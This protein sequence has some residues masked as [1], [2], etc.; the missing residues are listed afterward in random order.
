MKNASNHHHSIFNHIYDNL[1][2]F[3]HFVKHPVRVAAPLPSTRGATDLVRKELVSAG[4]RR[5]VELGP[6][7]GSLTAGILEALGP[8]EKPLCIEMDSLFCRRLRRRF[9]DRIEIVQGDALEA[10]QIVK[11]TLWEKPDAI[12]SSVPLINRSAHP[13]CET[14]ADMLSPHGLYLQVANFYGAVENYFDIKKTY[15]IMANF[16][17]EH[18]HIAFPKNGNHSAPGGLSDMG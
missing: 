4:V 17:P 7:L 3:I 1:L 14:I 16:P 18:L 13:L 8:D 11:G 10:P 12:V 9:G 15:H 2:F 5:V 6:G